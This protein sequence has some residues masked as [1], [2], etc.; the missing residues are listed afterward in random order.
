MG[1]LLRKIK[2]NFKNTLL[3][4]FVDSTPGDQ[5]GIYSDIKKVIKEL[6][7]LP[8]IELEDGLTLMVQWALDNE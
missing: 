7:W 2:D 5:H 4:E 1:E 6:N 3:V 8:K